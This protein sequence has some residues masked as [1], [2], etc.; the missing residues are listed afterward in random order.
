[1]RC[2]F[3]AFDS[4]IQSTRVITRKQIC[5]VVWWQLYGCLLIDYGGRIKYFIY[6]AQCRG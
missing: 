2:L 3:D 4:G 5:V 1:M 6:Q